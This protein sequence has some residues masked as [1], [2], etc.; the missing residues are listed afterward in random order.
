MID[1]SLHVLLNYLA[2]TNGGSRSDVA[3]FEALAAELPDVGHTDIH[4]A[5]RRQLTHRSELE[6]GARAP[7]LHPLPNRSVGLRR[8]GLAM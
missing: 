3:V 1:R 2:T 7:Q 5:L 8:G 4:S 6:P